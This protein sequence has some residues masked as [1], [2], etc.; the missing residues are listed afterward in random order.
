MHNLQYKCTSTL[1]PASVENSRITTCI[2]F[3]CSHS[4]EDIL[5]TWDSFL[6]SKAVRCK[7]TNIS[8]M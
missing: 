8:L 4:R 7:K 5:K 1:T 3:E 2:E 6:S